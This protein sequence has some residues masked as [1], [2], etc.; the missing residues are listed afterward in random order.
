MFQSK[1]EGINDK[2]VRDSKAEFQINL[3]TESSQRS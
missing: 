2:V 3:F 1:T